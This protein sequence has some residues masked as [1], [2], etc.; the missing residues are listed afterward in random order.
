MPCINQQS[1]CKMFLTRCMLTTHL[2]HCPAMNWAYRKV[3]DPDYLTPVSSNNVD[4]GSDG[5]D[6]SDEHI[7]EKLPKRKKKWNKKNCKVM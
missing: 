6:G 4:K 3:P 5:S 7:Y 2:M 1:G